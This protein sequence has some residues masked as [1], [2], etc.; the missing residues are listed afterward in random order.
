M[1][2]LS[3]NLLFDLVFM[4]KKKDI[5]DFQWA[6]MATNLSVRYATYE[7]ITELWICT[8]WFY[9]L[10][11]G[12]EQYNRIPD[13][14]ETV[15]VLFLFAVYYLLICFHDEFNLGWSKVQLKIVSWKRGL[16]WVFYMFWTQ[17]NSTQYHGNILYWTVRN[18]Y[19]QRERIWMNMWKIRLIIQFH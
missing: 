17:L 11:C 18:W 3:N 13:R 7:R 19:G 1:I 15:N 5:L 14:Y 16:S 6:S 2:L 10:E 12:G 8:K 4:F 9:R